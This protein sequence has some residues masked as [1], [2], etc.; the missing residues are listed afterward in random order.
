M[1]LQKGQKKKDAAIEW[2]VVNKSV[3]ELTENWIELNWRKFDAGKAL[4]EEC[5]ST[6][7][8]KHKVTEYREKRKA[9]ENGEK[10]DDSDDEFEQFDLMSRLVQEYVSLD[11]AARE[12]K[13]RKVAAE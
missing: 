12:A 11:E 5:G 7:L 4:V 10:S 8:M 1:E 3:T 2:G 9:V 13:K 6:M